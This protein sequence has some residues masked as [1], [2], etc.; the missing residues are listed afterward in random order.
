M[1]EIKLWQL[2]CAIVAALMAGANIG[3]LFFAIVANRNY[4]DLQRRADRGE[5]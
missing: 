4:R 3:F 5:I 2:V 1:I